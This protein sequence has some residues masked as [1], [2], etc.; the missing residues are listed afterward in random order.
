MLAYPRKPCD[1]CAAPLSVHRV[2]HGYCDQ[3]SCVTLGR[4]RL[5]DARKAVERAAVQAVV[6]AHREVL[7]AQLRSLQGGGLE[8]L[9]VPGI[10]LEAEAMP[11]SRSEA[12][13]E[14]IGLLLAAAPADVEELDPPL[15]RP[16]VIKAACSTCRGYCCRMGGNSA[17]LRA[18]TIAR[19]RADHPDMSDAA[20]RAVYEDAVPAISM[21]G[22]C[23]FHGELGCNL[24]RGFRAQVC[25]DYLCDP[26]QAALNNRRGNALGIVVVEDGAV[27]R[28]TLVT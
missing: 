28:S 26:L 10:H 6:A 9:H 14:Y 25:N 22:S 3:P 20:I 17:Y 21:A 5:L 12:L 13:R 4:Q 1:V 19:V 2:I 24:P 16:D 11:A 8:M 18:E 27:S 23:I 15:P 7:L